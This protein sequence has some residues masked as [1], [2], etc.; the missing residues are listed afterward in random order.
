MKQLERY[1]TWAPLNERN[2]MVWADRE[3]R[4][5]QHSSQ[6]PRLCKTHA[7]RNELE[8]IL[9]HVLEVEGMQNLM[10]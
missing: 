6:E 9:S 2:V 4:Q 1:A 3:M 7:M 8:E 5:G 10:Q